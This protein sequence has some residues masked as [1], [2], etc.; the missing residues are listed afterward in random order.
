[1]YHFQ[2]VH[3]DL[4]INPIQRIHE[5]VFETTWKYQ[6]IKP[7]FVCEAGYCHQVVPTWSKQNLHSWGLKWYQLPQLEFRSVPTLFSHSTGF[8]ANLDS[9]HHKFKSSRYYGWFKSSGCYS[10]WKLLLWDTTGVPFSSCTFQTLYWFFCKPRVSLS[11]TTL[12]ALRCLTQKLWVL[13]FVGA[14]TVGTFYFES[15]CR[16]MKFKTWFYVWEQLSSNN[17]CEHLHTITLVKKFVLCA[18]NT[19]VKIKTES[20]P[21]S[22]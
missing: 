19:R 4:D 21:R 14:V 8:S 22:S 7:R 1:M 17:Q 12:K 2:Q 13:Q 20:E 18:H 10:S 3:L 6:R 15:E 16:Q 5:F 11:I 9:I